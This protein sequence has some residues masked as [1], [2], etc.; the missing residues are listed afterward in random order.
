MADQADG[1]QAQ[2]GRWSLRIV[3][4]IPHMHHPTRTG[5]IELSVKAA[6]PRRRLRESQ[7]ASLLIITVIVNGTSVSKPIRLGIT[8]L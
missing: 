6:R 2:H 3:S 5:T 7:F 8:G 4:G 1:H